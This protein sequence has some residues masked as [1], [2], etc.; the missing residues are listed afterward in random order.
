MVFTTLSP[1]I[2]FLLSTTHSENNSE[3][4]TEEQLIIQL[5]TQSNPNYVFSHTNEADLWNWENFK[6]LK[7]REET[8]LISVFQVFKLKNS[9]DKTKPPILVL[10]KNDS[11]NFNLLPYFT[12]GQFWVELSENKSQDISLLKNPYD[13]LEIRK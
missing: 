12:N 10:W 3:V 6:N 5:L 7:T 13:I 2:R 1:N 4:K 11:G 8:N 9:K